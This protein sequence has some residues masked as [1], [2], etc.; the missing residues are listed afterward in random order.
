MTRSLF[1]TQLYEADLGDEALLGDLAHS[2]RT[3]ARGRRGRAALVE[4]PSL[5]RLHELRLAQR[6]A[7]ARPGVRRVREAADA[8]CRDLRQRL[9]VRPRAQ[10]AAR[11]PVGESVENRWAAQWTHP[12]AQ[13][14]LRHV[15]RR[16]PGRLG[17]DPLRGPAPAADDGRPAPR[18]TRSSASSRAPACCCCGKAGCATKCSPAP[19]RASGSRSASTSP[20]V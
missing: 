8:S 4:G 15:L 13:H 9:R 16:G 20:D 17:R 12:P 6:F 1:P 19:A 14:H 7:D 18:R 2:I 11:Q 3:L 5:C 10:A